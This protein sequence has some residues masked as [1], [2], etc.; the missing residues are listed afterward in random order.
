VNDRI[1]LSGDRLVAGMAGSKILY[2][3]IQ[4]FHETPNFV[5][6]FNAYL[7]GRSHG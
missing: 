4:C 7:L 5:M 6:N 1:D 3:F 2:R